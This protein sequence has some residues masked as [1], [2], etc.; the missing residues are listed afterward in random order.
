MLS[1]LAT[2]YAD[3]VKMVSPLIHLN[4]NGPSK[5]LTGLVTG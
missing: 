5:K 1:C 2:Y 3:Y 4:V